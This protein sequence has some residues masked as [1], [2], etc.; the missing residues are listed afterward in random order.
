MW[1]INNGMLFSNK[2][3]E[4]LSFAAKWIEPFFVYVCDK[5]RHQRKI[6]HVL[7]SRWKLKNN[8]NNNAVRTRNSCYQRLRGYVDYEELG[9][10]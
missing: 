5:S 7:L 3:Y 1:H 9:C 4:I 10:G 2:K 8:N 6:P